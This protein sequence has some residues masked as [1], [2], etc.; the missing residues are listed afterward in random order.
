MPW[1][2]SCGNTTTKDAESRE[3]GG[4]ETYES[5]HWAVQPAGSFGSVGPVGPESGEPGC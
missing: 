2:G 5:S 4:R 1:R 3:K